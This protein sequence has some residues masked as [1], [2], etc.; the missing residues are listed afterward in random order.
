M[1]SKW[2]N[3]Q[4]SHRDLSRKVLVP[5]LRKG[6]IVVTDKLSSHK[7]SKVCNLIEAA[8]AQLRYLPPEVAASEGYKISM[9]KRKRIEE[10]FDW[11]RTVGGFAQFRARLLDKLKAVCLFSLAPYN[12]HVPWRGVKSLA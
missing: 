6:D 4:R 10:V 9:R 8:G 11:G 2:T 12:G 7:G 3:Q 1:G 5:E